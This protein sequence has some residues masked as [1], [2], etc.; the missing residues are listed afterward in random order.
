MTS[1]LALRRKPLI[2]R[3][4]LPASRTL[5]RIRERML[6]KV[7][8]RAMTRRGHAWLGD[9]LAAA[10]PLC[11]HASAPYRSMAAAV[12]SE[13]PEGAML[14]GTG[15]SLAVQL[16]AIDSHFVKDILVRRAA[17][18]MA[19][20][21]HDGGY[22]GYARAEHMEVMGNEVGFAELDCAACDALDVATAQTRDW[23]LFT[24]SVALH[25]EERANDLAAILFRAMRALPEAT[26]EALRQTT[27]SLA[28]LEHTWCRFLGRNVRAMHTAV[29]AI[30]TR[31]A[32]RA[33][34]AAS[35][36]A[37]SSRPNHA[38]LRYLDLR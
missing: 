10:T 23:L 34:P 20:L 24:A 18:A 4:T 31:D 13:D 36:Q 5:K 37:L 32:W 9:A 21:H 15:H 17:C 1:S 2:R 19:A 12:G 33:S 27:D 14:L 38:L 35:V 16:D 3:A 11:P 26:S 8:R 22:L 29:L 25:Y 30:R 6:D 28:A 7:W